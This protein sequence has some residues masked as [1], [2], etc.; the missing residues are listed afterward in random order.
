MSHFRICF[1]V[2]LQEYVSP[3]GKLWGSCFPGAAAATTVQSKVMPPRLTSFDRMDLQSHKTS[4]RPLFHIYTHRQ[5]RNEH[6][7]PATFKSVLFRNGR[8]TSLQIICTCLITSI[9][10]GE[11]NLDPAP[12]CLAVSDNGMAGV[13]GDMACQAPPAP[14]IH[15]FSCKLQS[16][17][18]V[19]KLSTMCE[20]V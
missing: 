4:T 16:A 9:G 5:V 3:S 12:A 14:Q 15:H 1:N 8:Q 13:Y 17:A 19:T 7:K 6:L 18:P 10:A 2:I 20:E 11:T